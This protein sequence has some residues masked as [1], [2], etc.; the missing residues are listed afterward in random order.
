MEANR[1]EI[2]I[3][4][5]DIIFPDMSERETYDR[6]KG[7]NPDIKVLLSSDY[8]INGH[9]TQILERGC[10]GFIQKPFDVNDLSQKIRNILD[11][12]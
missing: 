2:D 1:D 11:K 4:I 6:L 7:I 8:S 9:A 10:N 3:V 12:D 5:L